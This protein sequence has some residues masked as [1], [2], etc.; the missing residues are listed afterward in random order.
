NRAMYMKL[1]NK[2]GEPI[3]SLS[4]SD[5]ALQLKSKEMPTYANN[6]NTQTLSLTEMNALKYQRDILGNSFYMENGKLY[7]P[8]ITYYSTLPQGRVPLNTLNNGSTFKLNTSTGTLNMV[9]LN[10]AYLD[11]N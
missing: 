6:G 9:V 3:A 4:T 10:N 7:N 1:S 5:S 2:K 8:Q 11:S